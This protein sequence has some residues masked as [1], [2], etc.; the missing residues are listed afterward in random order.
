MKIVQEDETRQYSN[1]APP[2]IY[3]QLNQSGASDCPD[4][5]CPDYFA[6]LFSFLKLEELGWNRNKLR[7][8][9]ASNYLLANKQK[10]I[11]SYTAGKIVYYGSEQR[12]SHL[13]FHVC[14]TYRYLCPSTFT[15]TRRIHNLMYKLTD[16]MLKSLW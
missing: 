9:K 2:L 13:S 8:K 5:R 10:W 7:S 15:I 4:K 12:V 1:R 14:K 11:E 16:G 6:A 3:L